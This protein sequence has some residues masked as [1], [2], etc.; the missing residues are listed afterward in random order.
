MV[1]R[2]DKVDPLISFSSELVIGKASNVP[3]EVV[4]TEDN[5]TETKVEE[6]GKKKK[7]L[8]IHYG[9]GD[10]NLA[11]FIHSDV[12]ELEKIGSDTNTHVVAMLDLGKQYGVP[13]KGAKIF[14]LKQDNDLSKI[15]SPV[16]K[17][18]G[19][20]NTADPKF[21]AIVLKEIIN[22]FPAENIAIFIGD[23]GA[24]WQGAVEDDS[25]GGKF[26]KI[27]EIREALEE[28]SKSLGKKIDLLAWDAC[29]MAMAEVGY[30]LKDAVKYMVAS[31][32][33]EGGGGYNYTI[34]FSK[35]M[36]E[37]LKNMQAAT[38][39]KIK[40]GP[41]EFAKLIVE[42]AKEYSHDIETISAVDL[43]KVKNLADSINSFAETVLNKATQEEYIKHL[44]D[45]KNLIDQINSLKAEKKEVDYDKIIEILK[46]YSNLTS[47]LSK[48]LNSENKDKN[49][50]YVSV[51][52]NLKEF[53]QKLSELLKTYTALN[54]SSSLQE[55]FSE[56]STQDAKK[57][58]EKITK[59]QSFYGSFRDLKHFM[60]LITQDESIS[61]EVRD[62]VQ[63]VIKA[64]DEYVIAEFHVGKYPNANGVTI[65]LPSYGKIKS[66]YQDTLF[67]KDTK[68]DE[69]INK[70][71]K[72]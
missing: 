25:H 48:I 33:L 72:A 3:D 58:K 45:Y 65:E 40:V 7:W 17:N 32:Q 46:D 70:I 44:K 69:M 54:V 59:T 27:H 56:V 50:D 41:E 42:A 34:L 37:A 62:K 19:Q 21:M 22:R 53:D 39:S 67:A 52:Q 5:Y 6:E 57:I 35:A 29:L 31:E 66:E 10:N 55:L 2:V 13:F 63:D 61:K 16:I 4:K 23:H 43:D 18:L 71:N 60:E 26:M 68:W 36:A 51:L 14:Y 1:N 9:A 49:E 20:V 64:I 11:R 30:E 24:G 15:N 38:L 28:V 47:I 8:V 12:N